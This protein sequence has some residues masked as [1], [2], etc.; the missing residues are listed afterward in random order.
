MGTIDS[1]LSVVYVNSFS[2]QLPGSWA[3]PSMSGGITTVVSVRILWV[4]RYRNPNKLTLKIR[5]WTDSYD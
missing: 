2:S 5:E 3:L 4:A 1:F